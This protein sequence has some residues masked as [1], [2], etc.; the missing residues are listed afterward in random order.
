MYIPDTYYTTMIKSKNK[1]ETLVGRLRKYRELAA[2]VL[3][4]FHCSYLAMT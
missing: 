2:N 1:F 3:R 4:N